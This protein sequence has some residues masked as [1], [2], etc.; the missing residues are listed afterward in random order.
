MSSA[1]GSSEER[2]YAYLDSLG[3]EYIRHSHPAV[4]TVEEAQQHCA[5]IEGA[6]C[7]NLLLKNK[8][9]GRCYLLVMENTKKADLKSL[10]RQLEEKKLALASPQRVQEYLGLEPGAVSPFGLIN[11][12][13]RE[14]I[15]LLDRD[16]KEADYINFHPNVNT[17][18]LTIKVEDFYRFLEERGNSVREIEW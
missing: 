2:L 10:A 7:K 4:Y 11:D 17:A 13:R 18:T 14:V 15:V 12:L 9:G 1:G 5:H 3:I 16:L 8:G 6:H